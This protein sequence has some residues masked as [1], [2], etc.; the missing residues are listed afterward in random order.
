MSFKNRLTNQTT[1][2][3]E[4]EC[5]CGKAFPHTLRADVFAPSTRRTRRARALTLRRLAGIGNFPLIPITCDSLEL[6]AAAL[7]AGNYRSGP[8]YMTVWRQLHSKAGCPWGPDLQ[9]AQ[10]EA[11]RSLRR[12]LGPAK[13]AATVRLED[14]AFRTN[15]VERVTAEGPG[16]PT[17]MLIIA[18]QWLPLQKLDVPKPH[19]GLRLKAVCLVALPWNTLAAE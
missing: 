3:H 5:E 16:R 2:H 7:K 12:G 14:V 11:A 17:D 4:C 18:S 10:Q 13:A 19:Q 15:V 9:A 1:R 8:S 6:M